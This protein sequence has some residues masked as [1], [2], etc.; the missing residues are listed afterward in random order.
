MDLLKITYCKRKEK[1]MNGYEIAKEKY[2]ALGV[3]TEK[4]LKKMEDI[5]ISVTLEF[6]S[7]T[8]R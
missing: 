6:M 8:E 5:K 4:A 2:A 3:D 1:T 7:V